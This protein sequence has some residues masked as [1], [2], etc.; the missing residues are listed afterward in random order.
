MEVFT[1][2]GYEICPDAGVEDGCEKVALYRI[3]DR[4]THAA[5]QLPNGMW[6]RKMG[7]DEDINHATLQSLAGELYGA[8]RC[9]M[10]RRLM[11]D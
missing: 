6:S 9:I 4:W 2:L 8:V 5:R 11:P 1:G 7:P 3:G 10:R